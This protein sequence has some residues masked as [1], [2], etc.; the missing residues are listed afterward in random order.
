M[1]RSRR[2]EGGGRRGLGRVR[3]GWPG[4]RS[5]EGRWEKRGRERGSAENE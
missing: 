2:K 1:L 4:L 3:I 5:K